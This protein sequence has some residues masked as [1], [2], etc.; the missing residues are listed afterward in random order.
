MFVCLFV[1]LFA[2]FSCLF[3]CLQDSVVCLFVCFFVAGFSCLF[4]CLQ[5]SV[6]CLFV[7]LFAGF[8]CLF[9]CLFVFCLL[10][11]LNRKVKD[12]FW[13]NFVY[14]FVMYIYTGTGMVCSGLCSLSGRPFMLQY[15][16]QPLY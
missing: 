9:V 4:V 8:S 13:C 2:G 1:C 7:C 12:R 16:V 14:S 5:D 10:A 11:G 3:V 6:V 15:V